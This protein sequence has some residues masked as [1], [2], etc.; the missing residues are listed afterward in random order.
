MLSA[1]LAGA[2]GCR[3]V[4]SARRGCCRESKS[5]GT[6]PD[7]RGCDGVSAIPASGNRSVRR[8]HCRRS[9]PRRSA[10][11]ERSARGSRG[12]QALPRPPVNRVFGWSWILEGACCLTPLFD[13]HLPEPR[14]ACG[15]PGTT[16]P[17]HPR[18]IRKSWGC[19]RSGAPGQQRGHVTRRERKPTVSAVG[20]R[21]QTEY[22]IAI[23]R[24]GPPFFPEPE[25]TGCVTRVGLPGLLRGC[26]PMGSLSAIRGL[27]SVIQNQGEYLRL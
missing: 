16:A 3:S 1:V 12:M 8:H 11:S 2:R 21:R 19:G 26:G 7:C 27:V 23:K 5:A 25:G 15:W 18:P 4:G 24:G 13:G 10:P 6:P 20:S 22:D 17:A 9:R 14:Y